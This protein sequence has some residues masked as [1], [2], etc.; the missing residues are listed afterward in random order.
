MAGRFRNTQRDDQTSS[1]KNRRERPRSAR[2]V[3][4]WS[5]CW[6]KE[7]GCQCGWVISESRWRGKTGLGRN[8][9]DVTEMLWSTIFIAS[10]IAS[11]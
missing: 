10:L 8:S 3:S 11:R 4:G 7:A 2:E 9:M 6:G 1:A 5:N